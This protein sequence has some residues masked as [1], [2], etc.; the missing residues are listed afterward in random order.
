MI[1]RWPRNSQA[2]YWKKIFVSLSKYGLL[3]LWLFPWAITVPNDTPG[4]GRL[5]ASHRADD[6]RAPAPWPSAPKYLKKK[7]I[8]YLTLRHSYFIM[9]SY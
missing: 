7:A 1:T 2:K 9:T 5:V 4:N 3:S 6:L 8:L